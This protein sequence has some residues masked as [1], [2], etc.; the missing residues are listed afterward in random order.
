MTLRDSLS[1]TIPIGI[2]LGLL[3]GCVR[4]WQRSRTGT[5]VDVNDPLWIAA[6]TAA[7]ATLED[8]RLLHAQYGSEMLVKFPLV[9]KNREVEH[10]WGPL[11]DLTQERVVVGLA[12]PPAG[13]LVAK[14][15]FSIATGEIE[16]WQ[17]V[18]PDGKVRGGFTS[19]AQIAL[20]RKSGWSLPR[21]MRE[22]EGKFV[23]QLPTEY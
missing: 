1:Y 19:Q 8:M 23:D 9:A 15:P 17:L 11:L 3:W 18:L 21:H 14:P 10:V 5:P 12:T 13:G 4:Q 16:D 2:G 22:A 20:S 6:I 7:R